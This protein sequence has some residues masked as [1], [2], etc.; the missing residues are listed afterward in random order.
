M[1]LSGLKSFWEKWFGQGIDEEKRSKVMA[2][3]LLYSGLL[4]GGM[5]VSQF[6]NLD[7]FRPFLMTITMTCLAYIMLEVG[8]EFTID[9]KRLGSYGWDYVVAMTAA[10]FPWIFCAIYFMAFFQTPWKEAFLVGRFAAPTSAGVLFAMLAAAGLGTTWLF[11]KVRIL[12]I[13]DD[14]DTIL[15]LIPLQIM[16]VGLKVELLVV[17][18]IILVLLG[19]AYIWLHK[20]KLP[21]GKKWLLGYGVLIVIFCQGIEHTTHVHLEVLL[22]AFALGCI[23]Y[24]PHDPHH[25]EQH[26]HEHTH[27]EPETG[28]VLM[29]DRAVKALFMFL[30]GCSLPKIVLGGVS[31]SLALVHVIALTLLSNLGKCF[32]AFC[33][34]KEASLKERLAVSVAMFPR[35]EVGAAVLFVALGY[36]IRGLP[37]SLAGLSLALNLLLTGVFI[38]AVLWLISRPAKNLETDP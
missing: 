9:K 17:I 8:L 25:P 10:A 37:V 33:Y 30:V 15:L 16:Y 31:I 21:T 4:I 2:L 11:R 3:V 32:P 26:E 13:F 20:L 36:G 35:G 6:F 22:P 7:A 24:N 34:R 1:R 29:M 27:I 23:L 38:S 19:A 14:L 28:W 12:A 18:L 5:A